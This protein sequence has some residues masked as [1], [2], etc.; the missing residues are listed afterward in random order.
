MTP[1]FCLSQS[2]SCKRPLITPLPLL[3]SKAQEHKH[4]PFTIS[5]IIL[6]HQ[7]ELNR[8]SSSLYHLYKTICPTFRR[9]TGTLNPAGKLP[10]SQVSRTIPAFLWR[11]P[12]CSCG[13]SPTGPVETN[14]KMGK[15]SAS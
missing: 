15:E 1:D 9:T 3:R 11:H 8:I 13:P 4:K 7:L 14:P 5:A 2:W 6:L 10:T 12:R